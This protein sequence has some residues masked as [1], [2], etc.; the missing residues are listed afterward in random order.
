M[1][2]L[3]QVLRAWHHVTD[4]L[5]KGDPEPIKALWSHGDDVTV[6]NPYGPPVRGWERVAKVIEH[7]ASTVRDGEAMDFEVIAKHA[8]SDLAYVVQI[9]HLRSK[10]G[11]RDDV[12]PYALRVTMVFR[13]EAGTWKVVHRH[14]DPIMSA[15]AAESLLAQSTDGA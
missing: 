8:A 12:A 9:E 11:S 2:D 14:A 5:V 4:A 15:Q 7:A 10:V 1:D 3:D 6:A 13:P